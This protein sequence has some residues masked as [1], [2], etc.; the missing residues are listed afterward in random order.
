MQIKDIELKISNSLHL[1]S[2]T[3]SSGHILEGV[4]YPYMADVSAPPTLHHWDYGGFRHLGG[5]SGTR[6]IGGSIRATTF[7][8]ELV[9]FQTPSHHEAS[10]I[11]EIKEEDQVG[12]NEWI[13][14][15]EEGVQIT[16]VS[17][18]N[19]GNELRKLRFN[20][21]MFNQWQAQK[22]WDENRDKIVELY[23]FQRINKEDLNITPTPI[24]HEIVEQPREVHYPT[25]ADTRDSRMSVS[26][27]D[28][29][30]GGTSS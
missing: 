6:H 1:K 8:G 15:V 5:S 3:G 17:L 18:P 7:R 27:R 13:A 22:W 4:Q 23:N 26:F 16:F 20:R 2:R 21:N 19:G 28:W 14:K 10:L 12:S 30:Q 24:E 9:D 11:S 25:L 29:A